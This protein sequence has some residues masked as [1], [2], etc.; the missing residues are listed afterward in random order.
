MAY[1]RSVR[2]PA[3]PAPDAPV[4]DRRPPATSGLLAWG[5][6]RRRSSSRCSFA[7][8]LRAGAGR[9]GPEDRPRRAQPGPA[10]P[11]SCREGEGQAERAQ[12][13]E[14]PRS[15]RR[16][17]AVPRAQRERRAAPRARARGGGCAGMALGSSRRERLAA[18]LSPVE[19]EPCESCEP[20]AIERTHRPPEAP[21][22]HEIAPLRPART[23]G[24]RAQPTST[25]SRR[26]KR[27]PPCFG[28]ADPRRTLERLVDALAEL[29]SRSAMASPRVG[30]GS[31]GGTFRAV[32]LASIAGAMLM[33]GGA[34]CGGAGTRT[35]RRV[36]A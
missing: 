18:M 2:G 21:A 19:R 8:I 35:P 34:G 30:P 28:P 15:G 5:D 24:C 26:P 14:R 12:G 22:N 29:R 25:R 7:A 4:P 3:A 9:A 1:P 36:A 13:R 32:A 17:R 16:N 31:R 23:H 20:F 33:R 6:R 10:T 11:T 27:D